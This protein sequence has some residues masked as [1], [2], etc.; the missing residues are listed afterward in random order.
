MQTDHT[1]IDEVQRK[2][3]AVRRGE[4]ANAVEQVLEAL[5]PMLRDDERRAFAAVMPPELALILA[6]HTNVD[7]D[8]DD[9]YERVARR[10]DLTLARAVE[11]ARIVCAAMGARLDTDALQRLVRDQPSAIAALF[12]SGTG[13]VR[14]NASVIPPTEASVAP[15]TDSISSARF[16]S[17]RPLS[18][19]RPARAQQHSVVCETNP[20]GRTKLSS[21]R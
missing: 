1:V 7:D 8:V 12:T 14:G 15:H 20:R 17:T 18:E 21:G 2:L 9:F 11:V 19:A 4:A 3:G 6:A 10:L 13:V 16:G 5:R